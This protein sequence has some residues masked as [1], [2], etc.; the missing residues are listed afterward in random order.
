[1]LSKLL[2]YEFKATS[3][4]FL[5]CYL[6]LIVTAF[7]MRLLILSWSAGAM[8]ETTVKIVSFFTTTLY[9]AIIAATILMTLVMII[10]R[11]YRNLMTG[12]GYLMH[13]L[14]VSPWQHTTSKL[15]VA[16][17]WSILSVLVVC[18]SLA[19]LFTANIAPSA[20]WNAVT[21]TLLKT[22]H[23]YQQ[24]VGESLWFVLIPII[25]GL[26]FSVIFSILHV[27][28][29]ITI[30]QLFN[31]HRVLGAVLAYIVI[32][33]ILNT[34]SAIF[35]FASFWDDGW[36]SYLFNDTQTGLETLHLVIGFLWIGFG[37][38]FCLCVLF[39][40]LTNLLMHRKLNLE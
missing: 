13:T 10:S 5:L 36:V 19:I 37:I 34:L 28:L 27:Y 2:K 29:S 18:A 40:G 38:V 7:P 39:F 22:F 23:A 1:M 17:I 24:T 11:F 6:A 33:T 9:I 30:G 32:Q 12:E 8:P 20:M 4:Q 14:P 15:I 25:L 16:L 31:K 3:R 35:S 26:L 21:D